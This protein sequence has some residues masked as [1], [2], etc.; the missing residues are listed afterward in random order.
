M[1]SAN[2]DTSSLET[3]ESM[4]Y[5]A[6]KIE[7]INFQKYDEKKSN[8]CDGNVLKDIRQNIVVCIDENNNNISE[9]KIKILE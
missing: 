8:M 2:F 3:I 5:G 7:F 4:F 9:F 6:Y 1:L